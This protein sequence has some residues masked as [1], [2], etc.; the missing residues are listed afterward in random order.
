[1]TCLGPGTDI[2]LYISTSTATPS[3][4]TIY[5]RSSA[6]LGSDQLSTSLCSP[7]D[8][9]SLTVYITLDCWQ[10]GQDFTNFSLL[11]LSS[12]SNDP[13]WQYVPLVALSPFEAPFWLQDSTRFIPP[14]G[15][16]LICRY[17][18]LCCIDS[19]FL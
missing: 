13:R 15:E 8:G 3:F 1:V 14:E 10:L 2:D 7:P 17:F 5:D 4:D 19:C 18:W 9:E 16:F 12:E 11:L 6:H